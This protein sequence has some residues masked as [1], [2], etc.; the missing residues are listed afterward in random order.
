MSLCK[1]NRITVCCNS[2]NCTPVVLKSCHIFNSTIT[3]IRLALRLSVSNAQNP[4]VLVFQSTYNHHS[5]TCLMVHPQRH[6]LFVFCQI[7]GGVYAL[8]NQG[9]N[10]ADYWSPLLAFSI[11]RNDKICTIAVA[12][13]KHKFVSN[14]WQ[15]NGSFQ[16]VWARRKNSKASHCWLFVRGFR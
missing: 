13:Y 9:T 1:S 6:I 11:D 2:T 7:Y 4:Y 3:V 12:S 8:W 16:F 5:G 10:G 14:R 15:L